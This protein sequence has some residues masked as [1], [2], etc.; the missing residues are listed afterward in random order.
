MSLILRLIAVGLLIP[1]AV[2]QSETLTLKDCLS[3]AR[4][5]NNT[6]RVVAYDQTIAKEGERIGK[7]GYFPRIDLEGG[8]TAQLDPQTIDLG[9][10]RAIATQQADY[11]FASLGIYQTLYDFG[12]TEARADRAHTVREAATLSYKGYEQDVFLQV[13]TSYFGILQAQQLLQAAEDEVIQMTDHLRVAQNL[14]ELGVVT[15][16]DLLQAEV[17]LAGS[18][19]RRLD[20]TN[21]LGNAWLQLNYLIDRKPDSR[22]ELEETATLPPT[23][24]TA[25]ED[26]AL[27]NRPEIKALEK[28]V[29]GSDL[30]VQETRGGYYPE[31]FAKAG[32]DYV[33]NRQ[34]REQAIMAATI[35]LKIN[36]FDGQATTGRYRQAVATRSRNEESLRQLKAAIGLEYRLA[37]NDA[38]VSFEKIKVTEKSIQQ[39]EENLRINK[40]RYQAQVGTATD[41]IDAQTLLTQAKTDYYRSMFDYQVAVARVKKALGEL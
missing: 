27:T 2:A 7:S 10:G 11:A 38:K 13:V 15:R 1:A 26:L 39:G 6:L 8:Y 21:R 35:G 41:V 25:S 40:D 4:S 12:R 31:I 5:S 30:E 28:S 16:N 19:Q 3:E 36:L 22:A 29:E 37:A 24:P 18:Q 20:S 34:V 17:R 14:F 32:L 23:A 33:Q 9:G